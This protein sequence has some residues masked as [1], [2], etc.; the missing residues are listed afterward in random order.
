[1]DVIG[2]QRA[3]IGLTNAGNSLN[4]EVDPEVGG[5]GNL[6]LGVVGQLVEL[7]TVLKDL[8]FVLPDMDLCV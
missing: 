6:D 5:L 3:V 8:Q 7:V 4:S 2:N 1:M